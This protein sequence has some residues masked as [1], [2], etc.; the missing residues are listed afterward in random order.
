MK[1]L[2]NCY[3]NITAADIEFINASMKDQ[4]ISGKGPYTPLFEDKLASY[5]GTDHSLTCSNA[6]LGILMILM[7]LEI[8]E[9]D[10][11][12][13]PATA[14]IMSVLPLISLKAKPVF[15]DNE[16]NS[17]NL[18]IKDLSKK[19]TNKTKLLINV[20]MWGYAN[21]IDEIAKICSDQGVK[22]LEDNSHCHGSKLKDTYLGG[23][24][25]Y[26]VFSTHER[27]LVT[28]GEGGFLLI[29]S[30][31]DYLKLKEIRSF[32]EAYS[33]ESTDLQYGGYGLFLGLNFKLSSINSAI[34]ITQLDK[35]EYKIKKRTENANYLKANILPLTPRISEIRTL[36][37]SVNNYYSLALLA[38]END[39]SEIE[40]L[41][42][43]Q[44]I[45]SDP[46][47][48][49]YCPLYDLPIVSG[50]NKDCYNSENLIN[51]IF[52]L[53]THEGLE[54]KDLDS[55]IEIIKKYYA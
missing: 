50:T 48:Y 39:K 1:K 53:P 30:E 12:L 40:N 37:N 49:K 46:L 9:G 27:K 22:V 31:T 44:N 35:L 19:I 55:M 14:P 17:F 32:G 47:R 13:L 51:Q 26:S 5:F 54:R 8:K 33:I 42:M 52:T 11:V 43:Q 28:T 10:E 29:K 15:V 36:D 20:P 2:D 4:M 24:G 38:A 34:G 23:F 7:L 45:I 25:D 3:V 18:C 41:L 21:N 6:T 16:E